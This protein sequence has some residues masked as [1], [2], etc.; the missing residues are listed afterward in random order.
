MGCTGNSIETTE[1]EKENM[2]QMKNLVNQQ[3]DAAKQM[4]NLGGQMIKN[5]VDQ[6][7]AQAQTNMQ[8][9]LKK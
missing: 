3:K 2:N 8:N 9:A 5:S 4:G 6:R 1:Q 7:M